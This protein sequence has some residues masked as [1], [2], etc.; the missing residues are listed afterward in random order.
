MNTL[1]KNNDGRKRGKCDINIHKT[2]IITDNIYQTNKDYLLQFNKKNACKLEFVDHLWPSFID[3][4]QSNNLVFT[5]I[6]LQ[7]YNVLVQKWKHGICSNY[8]ISLNEYSEILSISII[9]PVNIHESSHEEAI[10]T[11]IRLK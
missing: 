8:I 11:K 9:E 7:T 4:Y 3:Q 1:F 6:T 2:V 5:I 10:V